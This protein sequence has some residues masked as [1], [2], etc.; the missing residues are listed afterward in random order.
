MPVFQL[1]L[2]KKLKC[3][4]TCCWCPKIQFYIHNEEMQALKEASQT[5]LNATP[6]K[7]IPIKNVVTLLGFLKRLEQERT[8]C[9]KQRCWTHML[10]CDCSLWQPRN[11]DT[12]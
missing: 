6:W 3:C 12:L 11:E 1:Q 10:D 8:F 9:R 7:I 4:G 2:E 5:L